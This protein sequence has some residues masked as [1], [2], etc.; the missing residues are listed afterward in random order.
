MRDGIFDQGQQQS[1]GYRQVFEWFRHVH[2]WLEALAEAHANDAQVLF[3][4]FT[5]V[6]QLAILGIR[7]VDAVT[8]QRGQ[9]C[10]QATRL[11][12]AAGDERRNRIEGVEKKMRIDLLHQQPVLGVDGGSCGLR[13]PYL[14]ITSC[15]VGD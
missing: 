6:A 14:S 9:L 5:L 1:S 15:S 12:R 7:F 4:Q 13:Q 11:R 3:R 8:Q 10:D 2:A